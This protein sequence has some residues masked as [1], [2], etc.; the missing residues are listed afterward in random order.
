LVHRLRSLAQPPHRLEYQQGG[1]MSVTDLATIIVNL[2]EY[3]DWITIEFVSYDENIYIFCSQNGGAQE[4]M[5]REWYYF[6]S[7]N[8]VI[9]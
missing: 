3:Y 5:A 1:G 7:A 9:F 4:T 2:D 6:A 8:N